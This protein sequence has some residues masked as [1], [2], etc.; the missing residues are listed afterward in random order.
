MPPVKNTEGN[1]SQALRCTLNV[2][3]GSS[4]SAA[5]I[6]QVAN[7]IV[8]AMRKLGMEPVDIESAQRRIFLTPGRDRWLTILDDEFERH[9]RAALEFA[10]DLMARIPNPILYMATGGNE[11]AELIL[12]Q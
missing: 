7:A 11:I 6:E 4:T 3:V 1:L 10:D 9:P 5:A 8:T 2:F 12:F